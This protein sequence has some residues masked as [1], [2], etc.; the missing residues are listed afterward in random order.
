MRTG[1]HICHLLTQTS[2]KEQNDPSHKCDFLMQKCIRRVTAIL[3]QK[4]MQQKGEYWCTCLQVPHI[5]LPKKKKKKIVR[6]MI[7]E[8][9]HWRL[10][11]KCNS[12]R[13]IIFV[14]IYCFCIFQRTKYRVH[15]VYLSV[16]RCILGIIVTKH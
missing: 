9:I 13:N 10:S 7:N 4:V 8:K 16:K 14:Y 1:V 6:I 5:F 3:M 11:I 15:K 12:M 2:C